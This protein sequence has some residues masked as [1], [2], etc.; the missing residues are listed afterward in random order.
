MYI[1]DHHRPEITANICPFLLSL[2][3]AKNQNCY[4]NGTNYTPKTHFTSSCF[5]NYDIHTKPND[6]RLWSYYQTNCCLERSSTC[7]SEQPSR[8]FIPNIYSMDSGNVP[9]LI[10]IVFLFRSKKELTSKMFSDRLFLFCLY[11]R[12]FLPWYA[13]LHLSFGEDH[14]AEQHRPLLVIL[15]PRSHFVK[16]FVS[17][18]QPS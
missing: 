6:Q 2:Y 11:H 15:H 7:T 18:L 8:W 14:S 12:V 16:Q 5:M 4:N 9:I 10:N 17:L 3:E 13:E 1:F